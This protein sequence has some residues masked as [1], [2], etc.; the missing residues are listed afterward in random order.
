MPEIVSN[1][2][3]WANEN[4]IDLVIITGDSLEHPDSAKVAWPELAQK[5]SQ[6]KAPFFVVPGNHDFG[7]EQVMPASY[8][9]RDF[10]FSF[11]GFIFA[12]FQ[13]YTS[14]FSGMVELA[15]RKSLEGLASLATSFPEKPI[16]V[17][18]HAPLSNSLFI[19]AWAPPANLTQVRQVLQRCGNVILSLAGHIHVFTFSVEEEISYVTAP[20]LVESPCFSFLLWSVYPDRLEGEVLSALTFQPVT[21]TEKI[22]VPIPERFQKSLSFLREKPVACNWPEP[23]KQLEKWFGPDWSEYPGGTVL[24]FSEEII[25]LSQGS[26]DWHFLEQ[27]TD[28]PPDK[29]GRA[30]F[31]P[32]YEEENWSKGNLPAVYGY[33]RNK[34]SQMTIGTKL[35]SAGFSFWR[36]S[37]TVTGWEVQQRAMLRVASDKCAQVY[38]NGKLVD[39]E[40]LYHWADYW[41]RYILL[42][43]SLLKKG[44]NVLAV[45][46]INTQSSH[47][48]LDLEIAGEKIPK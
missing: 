7:L 27:S 47:G 21:G 42:P 9:G 2:V 36:K 31:H 43:S 1:F 23:K 38:L 41:N 11:G 20:G 13:T 32:E 28:P 15:E 40:R 5:L 29:N 8:G 39:E 19:P 30:W 14:R 33:R 24:S 16:I 35:Q 46:L 48:Y 44:E 25:L 10:W 6:M 26:A 4:K 34:A 3:R 17:L 45:K 22:T 37:F 18:T 12:G